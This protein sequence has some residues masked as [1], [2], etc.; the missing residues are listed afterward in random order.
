MSVF[1]KTGNDMGEITIGAVTVSV[2]RNDLVALAFSLDY[3][4]AIFLVS[5]KVVCTSAPA[6]IIENT[7]W[8]GI[9]VREDGS[10]GISRSGIKWDVSR[11]A[12]Q[13]LRTLLR[14]I[15][16]NDSDLPLLELA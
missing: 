9:S 12:S 6:S 15:L 8:S 5:E 11:A 16:L 4:E 13:R 10:Y 2:R 3:L 7:G 14:N 1:S